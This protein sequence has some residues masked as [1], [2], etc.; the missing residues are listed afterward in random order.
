MKIFG[1]SR[2]IKRITNKLNNYGD[3]LGVGRG[4]VEDRARPV[5]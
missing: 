2:K 1:K 4:Q 5:M 3:G